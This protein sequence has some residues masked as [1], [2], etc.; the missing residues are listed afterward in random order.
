MPYINKRP[1]FSLKVTDVF[2][3][4]NATTLVNGRLVTKLHFYELLNIFAKK[5]F[6]SKIFNE[7]L[8]PSSS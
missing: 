4:T 2:S 7:V 6:F 3:A 1:S 5:D 8:M